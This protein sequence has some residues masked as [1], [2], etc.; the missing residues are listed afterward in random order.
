MRIKS[1]C[2]DYRAGQHEC[3]PVVFCAKDLCASSARISDG[4]PLAAPAK[5]EN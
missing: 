1:D 2:L 5:E 4:D 3:W